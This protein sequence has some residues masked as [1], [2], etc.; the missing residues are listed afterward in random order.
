MHRDD[1]QVALGLGHQ[2]DPASSAGQHGNGHGNPV[3]P[4]PLAA[5]PPRSELTV[6]IGP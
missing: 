6:N 4:E 2:A 1:R 3:S 5:G